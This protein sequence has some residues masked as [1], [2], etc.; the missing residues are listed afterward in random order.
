MTSS[1][2]DSRIRRQLL[3]MLDAALR[4]VDPHRLVY[5]ALQDAG[6]RQFAV[7]AIGKAA[8]GML[9]GAR[10]ALGDRLGD[11]LAI[12]AAAYA[13][14]LTG[15]VAWV[16]G[17]HPLP[18]EKSLAA[19]EAL[20][21]FVQRQPRQRRLLFLISGGASA[22]VEVLQPDI[23]LETLQRVNNWLLGS[24]LPI[25]QVNSVRTALSRIKGG[26]LLD[27]TA[28]HEVSA[29]LISDVPGDD[30]A[31]IGSGLLVE[32]A[33]LQPSQVSAMQLPAWLAQL[34]PQ[35]V[36]RK[37]HGDAGLQVIASNKSALEGAAAEARRLGLGVLL[38]ERLL[39]G[40]A[41]AAANDIVAYLRTAPPGAHLWGGETTVRLPR[42]PGRGGRNQQLALAAALQLA[43]SSDLYLLCAGSDGVDGNSDD[44]GALVDGGS[45]RR[46]A[47]QGLDA[48]HH[49]DNADANTFLAASGDLVHTGPTGTN[50]MD[51]VI[52]CKRG[53]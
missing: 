41:V 25:H 15:D 30:P 44:A 33:P 4:A 5:T 40:D 26:G 2:A 14:A 21:A 35:G 7:V 45:V 39:Q 38:H 23:T 29:L 48:Q 28:G 51:V 27:I 34:L 47:V 46:G 19:G 18:D 9:D 36:F 13:E 42:S 43:G 24:G 31:C 49:L 8:T 37:A 1:D 22:M 3:Q 20:L 17:S 16:E 52:A 11:A 32:A 6:H 12:T 50:V 10:A 53:G